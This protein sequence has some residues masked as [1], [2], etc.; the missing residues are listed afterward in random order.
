M[1]LKK[2]SALINMLLIN[3][4]FGG[5]DEDVISHISNLSS[6]NVESLVKAI[7]ELV[8]ESIT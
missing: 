3:Q 2:Y 7:F 4:R 1:Y 6:E 8:G 5:V